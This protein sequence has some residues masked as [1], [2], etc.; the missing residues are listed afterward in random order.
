MTSW[1]SGAQQVSIDTPFG[2]LPCALS[3]APGDAPTVLLIHGRNGAAQ[4]PQIAALAEAY[5]RRGWTVVAPDLPFSAASPGLGAPEQATMARHL[6]AAAEVLRW[7]EERL[8]SRR[9]ATAPLALC[10]HS[11]GAYA[12][13]RLGETRRGLHHLCAVSPVVSGRH[14]LEARAAMGGDA[15]RVLRQE[16]P[17]MYATMADESCAEALSRVAAPVAVMTG[18][19]DGITP[20]AHARAYFAAAPGGCFFSVLPGLHHCPAGPVLARAMRAA[21][22]AVAA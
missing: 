16:V 21:L 10:G 6:G 4:Q 17:D 9:S 19:L 7:L 12:I 5:V 18:A 2:A 11:L 8:N 1:Q 20:P 14:L 15:L 13:A 3:A 22:D